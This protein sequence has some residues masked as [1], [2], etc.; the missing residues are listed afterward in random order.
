MAEECVLCYDTLDV[1]VFERNDLN[2][3]IVDETSSRL[4]CGHAYH[5]ACLLRSLQHRSTCPLCN[6]QGQQEMDRNDWWNQGRIEMEGRCIEIM[7]KV[8]R[9]VD[10]RAS[11]REYKERVKTIL[12][13]RKVFDTRVKEFK[14]ELRKEMGIDQKMK[15]VRKPHATTIRLFS[16]KAKM[17]GTLF[18]GARSFLPAYRIDKFLFGEMRFFR[19][20]MSHIF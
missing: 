20:R 5:T 9:D 18:A 8:K 15:D 1:P 12:K 16:R 11:I 14:V 6:V 4:Q 19:Y 13:E 2:D 7:E 10:V 3:I 17:E